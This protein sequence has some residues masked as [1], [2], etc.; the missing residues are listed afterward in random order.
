M[1]SPADKAMTPTSAT[2]S[3]PC[4]GDRPAAG[5]TL[6]ELLVVLVIVALVAAVTLPNLRSSPAVTL[7]TA[8]DQVAAALRQARVDA[9]N[10]G[11]TLALLVDTRARTLQVEH[12]PQ[13]RALP[14]ELGITLDTAQREMLTP[15]RGGIRFWPDGSATGGRVTLSKANIQIRVDVEWLTGRVRI[16]PIEDADG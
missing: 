2:G 7:K 4:P 15:D 9:M 11:Q 8:A 6:I 16:S 12:Q 1:A 13:A 5:F 14:D 10:K 3:K